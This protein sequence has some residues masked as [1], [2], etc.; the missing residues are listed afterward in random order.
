MDATRND[1]PALV[2]ADGYSYTEFFLSTEPSG[3]IFT[4]IFHAMFGAGQPLTSIKASTSE[5]APAT[6]EMAHEATHEAP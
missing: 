3:E 2:L 1:S 6:H 5:P 4:R